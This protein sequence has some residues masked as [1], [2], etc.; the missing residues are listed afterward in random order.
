MVVGNWFV[1]AALSA[2]FAAVTAMLAKVG[3]QSVNPD[4]ATFI[5]AVFIVILLAIFVG[6]TGQWTNPQSV[7]GRTW[8]FLGLSAVATGASWLCYFRALHVGQASMVASVDKLSIVLV[9]VFAFAFLGERP[10][11]QGCLGILLMTAGAIVLAFNK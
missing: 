3:I 11:A 5:R 4:L 8:M 9:A 1:W 6:V 10:S 2:V 7:P